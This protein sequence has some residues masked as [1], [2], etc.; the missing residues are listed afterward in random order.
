MFY[1]FFA[2][3]CEEIEA[4]TGVDILRRAGIDVTM[5][6]IGDKTIVGSHGIGI[7]CDSQ[8]DMREIENNCESIEGIILP[9]GM[10]GT[11]NLEK[12]PIVQ[13]MIDYCVEN[14]KLICAICAAPSILGRRGLLKNKKITCYP[15]DDNESFGAQLTQECVA[16]DGNI[17]TGKGPGASIEFALKIVENVKGIKSAQKI[18][19][20]LQCP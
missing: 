10:P 13:S 12:S 5:L 3:G 14:K 7:V 8:A 17:I 11:L 15:N 20:S 19:E 16:Q 1:A 4:V 2:Q 9:G 6:G 18:R